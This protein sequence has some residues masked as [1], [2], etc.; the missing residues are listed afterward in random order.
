[1]YART[2]W[3]LINFQYALTLTRKMGINYTSKYSCWYSKE[4]YKETQPLSG[5]LQSRTNFIV[6]RQMK[7]K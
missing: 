7:T 4:D 1:M 5:S 3:C 6:S 2:S